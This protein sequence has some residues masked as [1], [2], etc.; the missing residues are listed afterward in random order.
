MGKT[1]D[2]RIRGVFFATL[3]IIIIIAL[4]VAGYAAL[5]NPLAYYAAQKK[6]AEREY[7]AA[8]EEFLSLG[9]YSNSSQRH[10]Y[11]I[12]MLG[13]NAAD[14]GDYD[15][16]L[17]YFKSI[18]GYS[19]ADEKTR[20]CYYALAEGCIE[21]GD[22]D[23]A[24]SYFELAADYENSEERR[25]S[26]LYEKGHQ[27]FL[28]GDYEVAE[29]CFSL[30]S[31]D[32]ENYGYHHFKNFSEAADYI[33]SKGDMLCEKIEFVISDDSAILEKGNINMDAV[34]N[35]VPLRTA[36]VGVNAPEGT[37]FIAPVYFPGNRIVYAHRTG[38]LSI[39]DD[40]EKEVYE[41]ALQVAEEAKL[42]G[43]T[44]LEREAWIYSWICK[45]V[46]YHSPDMKVPIDEFL[47]LDE[48]TCIGAIRDGRANCQGYADA[49]YLIASLSGIEVRKLSSN[50]DGI[51]HTVN[52][53]K[54]EDEWYVVDTVYGDSIDYTSDSVNYGRLN[55]GWDERYYSIL[56]PK[57]MY[58]WVEEETDYDNTYY[59]ANGYVFDTVKE[60][61]KS[62]CEQNFMD[63]KTYS[64]AL[65]KNTDATEDELYSCMN[66][67][68][69]RMGV[70]YDLAWSVILEKYLDCSII[71]VVWK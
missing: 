9:D 3:L 64:Y 20:E 50:V 8:A 23:E 70:P 65:V 16:A 17:S 34:Y 55:F 26:L 6:L 12:Y 52:A 42:Q 2:K 37:L 54:L 5:K 58:S 38:D 31:D 4:A 39:L 60:A 22:T 18:A 15:T 51:G 63:G 7:E 35:L 32:I 19:N 71:T 57:E 36:T 43:E 68:L 1:F 40:D 62:V 30:I 53:V 41:T 67:E 33:R 11:C 66:E 24:I 59:G 13:K 28:T 49:F 45:S 46:D 21:K 61:A 10:S 47:R 25:N 27:L 56:G 14:G 29:E 69:D 48:L 44:V